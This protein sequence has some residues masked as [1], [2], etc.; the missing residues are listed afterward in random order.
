MHGHGR[1]YFVVGGFRPLKILE[2]RKIWAQIST[3]N[4]S[5]QSQKFLFI[6]EIKEISAQ[7][8]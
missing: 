2:N 5:S 3:Q 8:F 6:S 4:Q 1:N 7:N